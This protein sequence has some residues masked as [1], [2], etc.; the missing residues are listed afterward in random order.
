MIKSNVSGFQE[1]K[2]RE[3]GVCDKYHGVTKRRFGGD[4]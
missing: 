4:A 3:E 2:E 1:D